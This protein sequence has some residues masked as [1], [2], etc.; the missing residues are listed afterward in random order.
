MTNC[1]ECFNDN[2]SEKKDNCLGGG[3]YCF[4]DPDGD[5]ISNG[6]DIGYEVLY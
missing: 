5:K 6:K 1:K 2:Y 3:R 4:L